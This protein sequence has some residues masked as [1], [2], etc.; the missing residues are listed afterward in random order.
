MSGLKVRAERM[1]DTFPYIMKVFHRIGTRAVNY[2]EITAPQYHILSALSMRPQWTVSELADFIGIK[3]P[4]TSEIADRMVKVGWVARTTNPADRRQTFLK[5][6][7]KGKVFMKRLRSNMILS[8]VEILSMM[9]LREQS[10]F[11]KS[12]LNMA[13]IAE[14][15]EKR[16][17]KK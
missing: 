2:P 14:Q 16:E 7:A 12:V 10:T 17:H 8:Y 6:S 15:V 4:A 9:T 13:K 11:E 1:V 3:S 5:L